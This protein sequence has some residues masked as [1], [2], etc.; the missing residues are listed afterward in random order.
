MAV[1]EFARRIEAAWKRQEQCYLDQI[2]DAVNMIG[3]ERFVAKHPPVGNTA[4][5]RDAL[6]AMVEAE[7]EGSMKRDDLCGRCLEKM[8]DRCKHDGSCW[9]DKVIN[10]LSAPARNCDLNLS[11]KSLWDKFEDYMHDCGL[12]FYSEPSGKDAFDWL[13]A[14][15]EKRKGE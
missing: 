14:Q 11:E 5:I 6:V 4:S 15:A 7:T 1:L 9:V 2:R 12:P 3:H 8:W 13:L 10:A